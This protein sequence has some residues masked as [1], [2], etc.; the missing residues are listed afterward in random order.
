MN[1]QKIS[2]LKDYAISSLITFATAFFLSLGAQ[3]SSG[4]LSGENL[5]A[6]IVLSIGSVAAR[7][8]FKAVVESTFGM[9]G[10]YTLK[11]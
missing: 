3:L 4:A 7:A 6:S 5:G 9:G 8:A 1:E 11:G 10:S 2:V